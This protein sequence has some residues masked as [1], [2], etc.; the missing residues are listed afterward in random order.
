MRHPQ[1]CHYGTPY[2]TVQQSSA[3]PAPGP[4]LH[5]HQ[6]HPPIVSTPRRRDHPGPLPSRRR[7]QQTIEHSLTQ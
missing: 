7:R 4:L 3:Q 1:W 6:N 2:S 5:P